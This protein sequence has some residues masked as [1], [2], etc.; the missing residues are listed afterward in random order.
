MKWKTTTA[1]LLLAGGAVMA[2]RALLKTEPTIPLEILNDVRARMTKPGY[3][4][5][6]AL[7]DLERALDEARRMGDEPLAVRLL[8]QHSDILYSI[9][10][11]GDARVDIERILAVYQK[12]NKKLECQVAELQLLEGQ[13][14]EAHAKVGRLLRR[15]PD[16]GDAWRLR[17]LLETQMADQRLFDAED[18]ARATLV[19]DDAVRASELLD[20]LAARAPLDPARIALSHDL[21]KLFVP[22][23]EDRLEDV[24]NMADGASERF[25]EAR[26]SYAQSFSDG[27]EPEAVASFIDLLA[28]AGRGGLAADFGLSARGFKAVERDPA[29]TARLLETLSDQGR[30]EEYIS[31]LK[32]W[33]WE[34][35]P[36][37][38]AFYEAACLAFFRAGEWTSL[39]DPLLRLR[40]VGTHEQ[41][42]MCDYMIG[43][44]YLELG[45]P[46]RAIDRLER[47][48]RE[49]PYE[50]FPDMIA[51]S[52]YAIAR[53]HRELKK[54]REREVLEGAV[55]VAEDYSGEAWLRLVELMLETP[56]TG[57][58]IPEER[59]TKG[60][61]LLPRR[62]DE[63]MD[64]W[65]ELGEKS[66]SAAGR[67][68]G[69]VY[70]NMQAKA[71]THP[72]VDVGPYT[73]YRIA[74]AHVDA[75]REKAGQGVAERI[76]RTY[77]NLLPAID[78]IIE[79]HLRRGQDSLA[80]ARILDRIGLTGRDAKASEFLGRLGASPFSP[81]QL[82]N[83]MEID[84]TG[85]G[86]MVVVRH[87]IETDQAQSA[88]QALALNDERAASNPEV[89]LLE[90]RALVALGESKRAT[91]MLEPLMRHR[92][93]GD[94]ALE[95]LVQARL[96][97]GEPEDLEVLVERLEE[98]A[99]P[100]RE[101]VLRVADHLLAAKRG[102][103]ASV[104]LDRLDSEAET[105]GGDVLQRMALASAIAGDREGTVEAL[106]RAEA[107]S[108][109]GSLEIARILFS[110]E[111]RQWTQLPGLVQELGSTDFRP[112]PR[113]KAILSILEERLA[114]AEN[115]ATKALE[116]APHDPEWALIRAAAAALADEPIE[117]P[118]FFGKRTRAQTRM[119]M[120]RGTDRDPRETLG[121]LLALDLPGWAIW[122]GPKIFRI[123]KEDG[124]SL[125]PLYFNVRIM[126]ALGYEV[127]ARKNLRVLTRL[128]P[129]FG[130]GW[131]MSEAFA[132]QFPEDPMKAR[133]EL[134][135]LRRDRLA[136]LGP[137]LSGSPHEVAVDLASNEVMEGNYEEAIN[138]LKRAFTESPDKAYG[139][140]ILG[141]LYGREDNFAA[142]I[143]QYNKACEALEPGSDHEIVE[144]YLELLYTALETDE[145]PA[146]QDL[147]RRAVALLNQRFPTDPLVPLAAS[148]LEILDDPLNPD[149][150]VG[151]VTRNLEDFRRR[152]G[153]VP[154]DSL[155]KG[156]A[157]AWV[158]FLI[159]LS[160]DVAEDLIEEELLVTPGNLDLWLLLARTH[161][162]RGQQERA[163][164]LYENIVRMSGSPEAHRGAAWILA[165][166][167][168]VADAIEQHLEIADQLGEDE[169][170]KRSEFIRLRAA[171]QHGNL[172]SRALTRG[173]E[174]MWK[175]RSRIS[176]E[177]SPIEIGRTYTRLLMARRHPEDMETLVQVTDEY[178]EAVGDDPY[179]GDL[180]LALSGLAAQA[181]PRYVEAKPRKSRNGDDEA[182]DEEDAEAEGAPDEDGP[183]A[184]KPEPDAESESSESGA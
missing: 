44:S 111:D 87:L 127:P 117:L 131:N 41:R 179:A 120:G 90:A 71:L 40:T 11:Y 135:R 86:R 6:A 175:R 13:I 106:E 148:R 36:A 173:L 132:R 10:A 33:P 52:Y 23:R 101:L 57:Y 78:V 183:T 180:A 136:A 150:M 61:S 166:Q 85:T 45:K 51:D 157:R 67:D 154:L 79:S 149:L 102:S 42:S 96:S 22:R 19:A 99:R 163:L 115:V 177:V 103:L 74:L 138:G 134:A 139:R 55:S 182:G 124:G 34:E 94:Q 170:Q 47:Y 161:E 30:E 133:A 95:Y 174:Q 65:K 125:W 119:F 162:S 155:R 48:L 167:G 24:L 80:A 89:Q 108:S 49:D 39:T 38:A 143:A 27:V 76:L 35:R 104:L 4:E 70:G 145:S 184:A 169:F 12:N 140:E 97:T 146:V 31:I 17:G 63:L 158:E 142:A 109:D 50:A 92:V 53:A 20:E 1:L 151:R 113:Q 26:H 105:R 5:R 160:P 43:M 144:E 110:I 129:D 81:G 37:D 15:F 114:P 137:D 141:R 32:D 73:L 153:D 147:I 14:E 164:E 21:R 59:W 126:Q 181:K 56:N 62:V 77:P 25:A 29:V 8:T 123:K 91:N 116:I 118:P 172:D 93:F 178:L 7:R 168:A 156:G 82:L 100:D 72:N 112:N 130:P 46:D 98:H 58:R 18:A 68:F 64:F 16:F 75:G 2:G 122:A 107:F 60:M 176:D 121:Y 152:T 9:G 83:A 88:L 84:P 171:L 3:D 159:D 66:L 165:E 128:H 69:E 28:R 54:P